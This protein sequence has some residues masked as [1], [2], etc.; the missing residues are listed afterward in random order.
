GEVVGG[1]GI[2]EHEQKVL[3]ITRSLSRKLREISASLPAGVQ[4]VSTYHRSEWNW[5][6]PKEFFGPHITAL[7]GLILVTTL[8]LRNLRT[9]VG[10]IAILLFSVLF[11][12]LPL[13][14][15]GQTINL[16]S[17]AGLCIAIGEIA[18]ATIVIVENCAAELST[19]KNVGR[20]EKREII[21]R[22]I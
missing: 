20:A 4:I 15:F 5:T 19:R 9:A 11:T 22:S 6:K 2:K 18:D 10:P 3:G 21:I 13:A 14:V 1:G 12:A 8:V 17:L 16:F 7:G